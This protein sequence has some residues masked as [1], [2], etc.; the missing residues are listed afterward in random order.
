M[1]IFFKAPEK[2]SILTPA[3][4]AALEKNPQT[5]DI[6]QAAA[7][8]TKEVTAKMEPKVSWARLAIAVVL[9]IAVFGAGLYAAAHQLQDWN[10]ALIHSFELVLGLVLGLLG[11][12]A[13]S[14]H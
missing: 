6:K 7:N 3:M 13:A 10:S 1:G 4:E 12:E 14:Q 2:S 9:L 11:G 8:L 5:I